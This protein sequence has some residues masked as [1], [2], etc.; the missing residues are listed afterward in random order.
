MLRPV[1]TALA[2]ALAVL[3][4]DTLFR[5]S[6]LH[7]VHPIIL[8]PLHQ[9]VLQ[10]PL[11]LQWSGPEEMRVKL[12]ASGGT[13]EDLGVQ[14][15]PFL[16]TEESF[17]R[18]GGYEIA[19]EDTSFG[20]WIRAQ[21]V[22]RV[23]AAE[24]PPVVI[25]EPT[26]EPPTNGLRD[27]TRALESARATRNRLQERVRFLREENRAIEVERERLAKELEAAYAQ[28]DE[29]AERFD[30][31]REQG[32]QLAEQNAIL[33]EAVATL[34]SRLD[35]VIPCTVWGYYG[36]YPVHGSSGARRTV[37][38]S[39]AGGQVFRNRQNCEIFRASDSTASST[40]SCVGRSWGN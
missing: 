12:K 1:Y 20:D 15:S 17:P 36:G 9:A 28:Q 10:P 19:I 33:S 23:Y 21:R 7:L 34:K 13:M 25:P 35:S 27:L 16:L 8:T 31:L 24:T 38:V 4:A 14:R 3:A 26:P 22:F 18:E 30:H 29:E 5:G 40:C 2:S 11:E 6:V 37:V 39:D 32:D